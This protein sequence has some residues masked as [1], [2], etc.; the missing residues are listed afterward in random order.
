MAA[1]Q[2][3]KN[4][5]YNKIGIKAN[6]QA[7]YR[8]QVVFQMYTIHRRTISSHC[9]VH[10]THSGCKDNHSGCKDN[11]SGCKDN[12]FESDFDNDHLK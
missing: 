8:P 12:T 1:V 5:F 6:N 11:H 10:F 2:R 4:R 7:R 9:Y 3:M